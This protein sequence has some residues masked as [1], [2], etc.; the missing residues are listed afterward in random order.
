MP[1][2]SRPPVGHSSAL[3]TLPNAITFAR[4]CAVPAAIYLVLHEQFP[5]AFWLFLGAG[6]SDAVDGWLARRQ[7]TTY[8][9]AV[10]DPLADKALLMA[11]YV[12]LSVVHVLPDWLAIMVVFRDLVIMGGVLVLNLLGQPPAIKPLM[13]SKLNTVLQIV[14]V[15]AALLLAGLGRHADV[16]LAVLTW[17]VAISTTV[18]GAAYI[19]R[20][21]RR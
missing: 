8:I 12:V 5:A 9:G 11:M 17:M 10:L 2:G 14:L 19:V 6:A 18:S 15:A 7:G 1:D 4:L 16:M 13:I 20:A 21:T 3:M